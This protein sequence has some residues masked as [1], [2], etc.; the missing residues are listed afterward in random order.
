MKN[1]KAKYTIYGVLYLI[2]L[3][4]SMSYINS[5]FRLFSMQPDIYSF[6]SLTLIA[7]S[8]WKASSGLCKYIVCIRL[9][10]LEKQEEQSDDCK[11]ED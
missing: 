7:F 10:E 8:F 1:I 2:I 4:I 6:G 11:R 9:A 3:I 5:A